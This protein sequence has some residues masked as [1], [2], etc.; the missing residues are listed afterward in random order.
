MSLFVTHVGSLPP[1]RSRTNKTQSCYDDFLSIRH[2]PVL[3]ERPSQVRNLSF[4]ETSIKTHVQ[5]L[6]F[7][8]YIRS[9]GR[10]N[11]QRLI[12]FPERL[13]HFFSRRHPSWSTE[14]GTLVILPRIHAVLSIVSRGKTEETVY[15]GIVATHEIFYFVSHQS[16]TRISPHQIHYDGCL[17]EMQL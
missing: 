8:S 12:S 6:R 5:T 7:L 17:P 10:H 13:I 3:E 16:Y 9:S 2:Q 1:L 11:T 14:S 4:D 15:S